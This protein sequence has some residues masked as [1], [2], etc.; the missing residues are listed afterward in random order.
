MMPEPSSRALPT[1]E[2]AERLIGGDAVKRRA[3]EDAKKGLK[4]SQ[5][6]TF[7]PEFR[8]MLD[9]VAGAAIRFQRSFKESM[10]KMDQINKLMAL[11][12]NAIPLKERLEKLNVLFDEVTDLMLDY[13]EPE[14]TEFMKVVVKYRDT[15][16]AL[17]A[18]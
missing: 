16:R 18:E 4:S 13:P 15:V 5:Y 6:D 3:L 2:E 8:Q 1:I 12:P 10:V 7:P 17:K 11:S 14:R 9:T